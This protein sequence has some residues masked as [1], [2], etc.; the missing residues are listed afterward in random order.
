MSRKKSGGK[1]LLAFVSCV[2]LMLD[3][4]MALL[5]CRKEDPTRFKGL[6]RTWGLIVAGSGVLFA[7]AGIVTSALEVFFTVSAALLVRKMWLC[8]SER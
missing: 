7:T 3:V 4:L 8:R 1:L 5:W 2:L 6:V